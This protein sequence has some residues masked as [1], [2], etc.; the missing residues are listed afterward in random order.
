MEQGFKVVHGVM[1][2][3]AEVPGHKNAVGIER[4]LLLAPET[5]PGRFL[6]IAAHYVSGSYEP[7]TD[8]RFTEPS[9]HPFDEINVVL[10][11][12]GG[13][14]QYRYEVGGVATLVDGPCT[15]FI[16]AGAMHRMEP[17][18]GSGIFL[19]IQALPADK[20]AV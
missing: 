17:V 10:P 15:V 9:A 2:P 7:T 1:E 19:C 12:E 16:P 18:G 5:V 8:W 11:Y 6:H 14:L 13:R 20:P 3:L 4:F